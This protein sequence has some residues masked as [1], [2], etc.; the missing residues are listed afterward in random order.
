MLLARCFD[1]MVGT[2][3]A[4]KTL[5]PPLA[6]EIPASTRRCVSAE[7][8]VGLIFPGKA[9]ANIDLLQM[10]LAWRQAY[11]TL[12]VHARLR[13]HGQ[14]GPS[15]HRQPP[16]R[17]PRRRGRRAEGLRRPRAQR[18]RARRPRRLRAQH[19]GALAGMGRLRRV[20]PLTPTPTLYLHVRTPLT[21]GAPVAACSCQRHR[22]GA[23]RPI[24]T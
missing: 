15:V 1:T 6:G 17:P 10:A 5:P 9:A 18:R 11:G 7:K 24:Q 22:P 23:A 20:R 12:R 8:Q 19:G 3:F 2:G 16:R 14:A 21:P 4:L 13:A